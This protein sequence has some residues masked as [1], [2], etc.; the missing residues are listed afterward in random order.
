MPDRTSHSLTPAA[1]AAMASM[2]AHGIAPTP[3]NFTVWLEYHSDGN[4][5]LKRTLDVLISNGRD[6][7]ETVLAEL[8]ER[9]FTPSREQKA[10][11]ETSRKVQCTLQ[12]VQRLLGNATADAVQY[13][14]AIDEITAQI[15]ANPAQLAG[16]IARLLRETREMGRRTELL[17]RGIKQS[18]LVIEQLKES[19]HDLRRDAMTDGLTGIAN[20]K[21]FDATLR[22]SVIQSMER[23]NELCLLMIDIDHFKSFNDTYGHQTG[24]EVLKLVARMLR[25]NVPDRILPARYGGE[26]FAVVLPGSPL[27]CAVEIGE[28]IRRSFETRQLVMKSSRQQIGR[29]TVSIGAAQFAPGEPITDFVRRAD[30]ALYRAKREGRNRLV[31]AGAC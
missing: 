13:G 27:A 22:D 18:S 4:A 15:A 3:S 21:Q 25:E 2:E 23:G 26:E 28:T 7:S 12:E 17:D 19:L 31:V 30:N 5:E 6:F 14:Q 29:I 20:R 11:L 1:Q 10:L 8:Y 16:L 9:F 24:D